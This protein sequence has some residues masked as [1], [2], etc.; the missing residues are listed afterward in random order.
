MS[1][2][3]V[4]HHCYFIIARW[5]SLPLILIVFNPSFLQCLKESYIKALGIGLGFDL[6]R[7]EFRL[8]TMDLSTSSV[9]TDTTLYLRNRHDKNWV[10]QEMMLD[11]DHY[12][13]VALQVHCLKR[14]S[15]LTN[16]HDYICIA[17]NFL[18]HT[19]M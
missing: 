9:A 18:L 6:Q 5:C 1:S 7:A 11:E 8:A 2:K 19:L 3:N 17:C 4:T 15:E 14:T 12:V 10:F 16:G 13:A